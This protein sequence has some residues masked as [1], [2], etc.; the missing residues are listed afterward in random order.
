MAD[1]KVKV[2][3]TTQPAPD[4]VGRKSDM[5]PWCNYQNA[6]EAKGPVHTKEKSIVVNIGHK[7]QC[8]TCGKTWSVESLG[9]P[10]TFELEMG[11]AWMRETAARRLLES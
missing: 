1:E 9:K 7:Q 3:K 4:E 11:P 10:W 2:L 6:D 5:C 8:I